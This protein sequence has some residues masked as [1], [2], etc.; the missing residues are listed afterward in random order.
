MTDFR[1]S[2]KPLGCSFRLQCLLS[3]LAYGILYM[4]YE[5]W[6]YVFVIILQIPFRKDSRI[7]DLGE[8]ITERNDC[9]TETLPM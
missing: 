7:G 4:E 6:K 2:Y 5:I 3:L 9:G 8:I 1:H